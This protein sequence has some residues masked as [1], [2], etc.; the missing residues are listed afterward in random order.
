MIFRLGFSPQAAVGQHI[1][2][3]C[4]RSDSSAAAPIAEQIS[5]RIPV[6]YDNGD[7]VW[8]GT[9][10][11]VTQQ[12]IDSRAVVFFADSR[13]FAGEDIDV[14]NE[15]TLAKIYSKP[16][17]CVW[18][19][20]MSGFDIRRLPDSMYNLWKD[21]QNMSAI[22]VCG[23]APSEA[24]AAILTSVGVSAET[25]FPDITAPGTDSF[26]SAADHTA[27][28]FTPLPVQNNAA[29]GQNPAAVREQPKRRRWPLWVVLMIVGILVILCL[30][31]MCG[32]GS[33][34]SHQSAETVSA[35]DTS[36][37]EYVAEI[38]S[39]DEM[40]VND[41]FK[42]GTFDNQE[43]EWIVLD[44]D[45]DNLLLLSK[46]VLTQ[47]PFDDEYIPS[48]YT[49]A[50]LDQI[51]EEHKKITVL[52]QDPYHAVE[53]YEFGVNWENCFLR[54]WLNNE[55]LSSAFTPDEQSRIHQTLVHTADTNVEPLENGV[56]M[57]GSYTISSG[58]DTTDKIFL[59]SAE[60]C[61]A[62][63][64]TLT[65]RITNKGWWMR[66][67]GYGFARQEVTVNG[68]AQKLDRID[69]EII[70]IVNESGKPY[71]YSEWRT[72]S[73]GTYYV[74]YNGQHVY[75]E[76]GVRPAMWVNVG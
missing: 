65:D 57:F 5:R 70:Q 73:N 8:D 76:Y 13:L 17:F 43:I 72:L 7:T 4:G 37:P 66:S 26:G 35:S 11:E 46:N 44:K 12:L 39:A 30:L 36:K 45:G 55:F 10:D 71:E 54:Q 74:C 61:D 18:C 27:P 20:D 31:T 22:H 56:N 34:D 33:T 1:F 68:E 23:K 47:Q 49:Q 9:Q 59:L 28:A 62:Y 16:C 24:A 3:V 60:E 50:R 38:A 41:E 53:K 14:C 52:S 40:Q 21:F 64:P 69:D 19:E 2:A 63:L 67:N 58:D 25:D 32:R 42:F 29:A 6:W 75:D 48:R 15:L 51:D